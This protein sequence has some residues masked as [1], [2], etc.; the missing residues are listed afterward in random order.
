[1][2]IFEENT[3]DQ[4]LVDEGRRNLVSYFETKGFFDVKVTSHMDRQPDRVNVE[5]QIERGSKHRVEGVFFQGNEFFNDAQLKP[6]SQIKKG[7]FFFH[8]TF[9]DDALRK[10]VTA[11]TAFYKNAGFSSVAIRPQVKISGPRWTSRLKYPRD[12]A[13][14]SI[15]WAS[16]I[17]RGMRLRP[18]LRATP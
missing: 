4:D 2:P 17:P 5:Y 15:R 1:M 10:S 3:V 16:P 14:S 8:G 6:L 13:I 18:L 7:R 11:L 12:R 9:S